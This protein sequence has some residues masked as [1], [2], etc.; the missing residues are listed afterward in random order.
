MSFRSPEG[1]RE[2]RTNSGN[3]RSEGGEEVGGAKRRRGRTDTYWVPTVRQVLARHFI[4][5]NTLN[6]HKYLEGG[7]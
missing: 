1:G 6:L 4:R 5:N 7:Y 2:N 3:L